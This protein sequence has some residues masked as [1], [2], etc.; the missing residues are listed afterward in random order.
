MTKKQLEEL[1]K[2]LIQMKSDIL[3]GGFQAKK[4]DLHVSSDD[5]SD[6]GDLANSVVEQQVSF[7]MRQREIEK[8]RLIDQALHR[9][10]E[11]TYGECD[12]CGEPIGFKRLKNQPFTELCITHA[13][14][15]EREQSRFLKHG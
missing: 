8:L 9:I 7:S 12:D 15:A 1:K 5:L 11:G 14:E 13:E 6:D 2:D 4:E 10:E 3:N